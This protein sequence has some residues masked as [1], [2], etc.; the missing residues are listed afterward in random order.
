MCHIFS[1]SD[2]LA[3]GHEKS[4]CVP[5]PPSRRGG[6]TGKGYPSSPIFFI[7][8]FLYAKQKL[9]IAKQYQDTQCGGALQNNYSPSDR[10][11]CTPSE[12]R[13]TRRYRDLQSATTKRHFPHLQCSQAKYLQIKFGGAKPD[14]LNDTLSFSTKDH[15]KA[16][17]IQRFRNILSTSKSRDL[18]KQQIENIQASVK[19]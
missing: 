15:L 8:F 4:G 1:L 12:Q 7:F 2:S 18:W 6:R 9:R 14:D 11:N 13:K 17:T 3:V 10:R 16:L 5:H 19:Q